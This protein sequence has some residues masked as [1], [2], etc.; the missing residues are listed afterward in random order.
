MI[1]DPFFYLCAIPAVLLYGIAKGGFGGN[2]AIV[3]VPLMAL[4]VTPTRS[5]VMAAPEKSRSPAFSTTA[6]RMAGIDS[7]KLNRAAASRSIPRNKPAAMVD[8]EREMPGVIARPWP[9]PI[10]TA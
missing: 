4:V 7:K 1:T 10:P 2:I 5:G 8:P 6:P 3:S 9:K